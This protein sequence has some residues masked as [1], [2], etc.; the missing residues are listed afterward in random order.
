M[1][2]KHI[3]NIMLKIKLFKRNEMI[4]NF[5]WKWKIYNLVDYKMLADGKISGSFLQMNSMY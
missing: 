5:L 2:Q 3:V 4:E 1:R